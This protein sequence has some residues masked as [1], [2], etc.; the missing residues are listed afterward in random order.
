MPLTADLD[1]ELKLL[2]I[3]FSYLSLNHHSA[4]T[5]SSADLRMWHTPAKK[6][7][8]MDVTHAHTHT[9]RQRTT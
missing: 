3:F 4:T 5:S 7:H 2:S 1:A 9:C 8:V 6:P